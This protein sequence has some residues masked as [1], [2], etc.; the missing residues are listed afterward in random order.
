MELYTG[1]HPVLVSDIVASSYNK[2]VTEMTKQNRS[3][4]DKIYDDIIYPNIGLFIIVVCVAIF[5]L[6][7]YIVHSRKEKFVQDKTEYQPNV[8]MFGGEDASDERIA[9]PIFN[10][11]IPIQ[12]QESYVK[13]LPD[14]IPVNQNGEWVDNVQDM[15]YNAPSFNPNSYQFTGPYYH[16]SE[17]GL[18][19]DGYSEFVN[20]N[21]QNLVDYD[22]IIGDKINIIPQQ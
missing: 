19:D 16:A 18:S 14:E 17:N 11:S 9:R 20:Y 6:W 21:K 4:W 12:K 22:N 1:S 3:I 7:R 10:P 5:L 15:P 8:R 13:Y 2:L